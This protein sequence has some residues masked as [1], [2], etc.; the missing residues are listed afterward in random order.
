MAFTF[1]PIFAADPNN[2]A[3]VASNAA[4][5]IFD[6]NDAGKAPITITDPTGSPI[7]NPVTV[8][9]NGFGTAFQHATLDRVGWSGGGFEGYFTSYE[10]LKQVA[11]DAQ[12]AA[13]AAGADAA[14]AATAGVA[15]VAAN[16]AAA[17]AAA[18]AAA[19]E[20]AESAALVGAPADSAIATAVN[21]TAT[22]TKAALNAAYGPSQKNT[23]SIET[24]N[25]KALLTWHNA[26]ASADATKVNIAYLG[27]SIVEGYTTAKTT[28]RFATSTTTALRRHRG[29]TGGLGYIKANKAFGATDYPIVN[30]GTKLGVA[31]LGYGSNA[32][33]HV[34]TGYITQQTITV[35][36]GH[37]SV[38]IVWGRESG[39]GS[40]FWA[41]D[42]G[43]TTSVSTAGT[44]LRWNTTRVTV[45]PSSAH[46]ITITPNSGVSR[47][48]GAVFYAGDETTGVTGFE[49]GQPSNTSAQILDKATNVSNVAWLDAVAATQPKLIVLMVLCNDYISVNQQAGSNNIAPAQSKVNI[50]A[51]IDAIA[52]KC[53]VR[54]SVVLMVDNLRN[55]L[56][57][58]L[59]Y[60][61]TEYQQAAYELAAT[62]GYAV[63]DVWK[64]MGQISAN[65]AYTAGMLDADRIHPSTTGHRFI[66]ESLGAFLAPH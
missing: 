48:G 14:A 40:F 42:G 18:E 27:H 17:Q 8:N 62:E 20:A 51:F 15:D 13:E 30:T 55:N 7:S 29:L 11:L 39:A 31:D 5:T 52:A 56:E 1:D 46:T 16:A 28:D 26:L 37:T 50:K 12:A 4:I 66:G 9:K 24:T 36:A 19:S 61:W 64:R 21:G 47:L 2:P 59:T 43:A 3:N 57:G 23:Q 49:G 25:A 32:G 63:F 58:Q 65:D 10:G 45:N 34:G 38:D 60:S 22:E 33:V 35:P 44:K 6:P 41:L 54:P 53:T